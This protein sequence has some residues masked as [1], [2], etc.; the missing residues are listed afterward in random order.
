MQNVVTRT[1]EAGDNHEVVIF[2][3][4]LDFSGFIIREILE[5]KNPEMRFQ[6]GHLVMLPM[7]LPVFRHTTEMVDGKEEIKSVL[8]HHEDGDEIQKFLLHGTG[9]TREEALED[10]S[11]KLLRQEIA[12]AKGMREFN[13]QGR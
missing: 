8:T 4:Y 11:N 10:A 2:K 13:N 9:R 12:K 7:R 3:E 5:T 1:D 6:V